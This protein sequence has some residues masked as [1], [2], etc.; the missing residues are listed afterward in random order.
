MYWKKAR[1]RCGRKIVRINEFR[2]V[3]GLRGMACFP[4]SETEFVGN[5][6]TN[7]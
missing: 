5:T 4:G 2:E 3:D 1:I 7:R 6:M